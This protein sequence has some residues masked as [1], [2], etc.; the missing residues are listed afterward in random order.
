MLWVAPDTQK[1]KERK[2]KIN[3]FFLLSPL[4]TSLPTT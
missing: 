4:D 2:K 1:K 3:F